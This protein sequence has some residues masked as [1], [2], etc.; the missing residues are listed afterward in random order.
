MVSQCVPQLHISAGVSGHQ[1]A[2]A[3]HP[4]LLH[5]GEC[6]ESRTI[7]AASHKWWLRFYPNGYDNCRIF[8]NDHYDAYKAGL[9][10]DTAI[11]L[12]LMNPNRN[13]EDQVVAR[14][15]SVSSAKTAGRR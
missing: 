11:E 12:N 15:S 7:S 8:D 4:R 2:Y 14:M 13:D 9:A 3:E 6:I 10:P 5:K 1:H